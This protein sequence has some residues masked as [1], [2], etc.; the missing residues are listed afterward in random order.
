MRAAG[1]LEAA[2]LMGAADPTTYISYDLLT[3]DLEREFT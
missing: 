1:L 3:I 2:G